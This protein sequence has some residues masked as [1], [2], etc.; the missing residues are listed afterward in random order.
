[1][2]DPFSVLVKVGKAAKTASKGT[3][4]P[5]G[6][7]K[8]VS[9]G[10]ADNPFPVGQPD[11]PRKI[12]DQVKDKEAKGRCDCSYEKDVR[13]TRCGGRCAA[14]KPGGRKPACGAK[15]VRDMFNLDSDPH[16]IPKRLVSQA[17]NHLLQ[18]GHKGVVLVEAAWDFAKEE[19]FK[20]SLE[21]GKA[22]IQHPFEGSAPGPGKDTVWKDS[23][24][25]RQLS[26]FMLKGAR[27]GKKNDS[28]TR[29]VEK[30]RPKN[31][32]NRDKWL[33]IIRGKGVEVM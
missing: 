6:P 8:P 9:T 1:M 5:K 23:L 22:M 18:A 4:F 11:V 21:V 33:E 27:H 16:E 7:G 3:S 30:K 25:E 24:K 26:D 12:K 32:E 2:G 20:F 31:Q 19:P 28:I 15:E 29:P 14:R 17:Y 13:G 10:S